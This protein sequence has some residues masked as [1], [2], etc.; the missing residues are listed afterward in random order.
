[1][2]TED[3]KAVKREEPKRKEWANLP[4]KYR[5]MRPEE[6]EEMER[7][8]AE[9]RRKREETKAKVVKADKKTAEKWPWGKQGAKPN[10][11]KKSTV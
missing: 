4:L 2:T 7:K 3:G 9:K 6:I 1:M 5:R 8:R 11:K 10:L